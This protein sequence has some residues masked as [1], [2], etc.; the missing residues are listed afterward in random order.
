MTISKEE[1][2]HDY[3]LYEVKFWVEG[4][5]EIRYR[6]ILNLRDQVVENASISSAG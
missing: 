1:I 6:A 4:K 5:K 2:L 3:A